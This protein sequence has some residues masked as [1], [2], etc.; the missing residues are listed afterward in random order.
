[1][2]KKFIRHITILVFFITFFSCEK[3]IDKLPGNKIINALPGYMA[4]VSEAEKVAEDAAISAIKAG[5]EQYA[6]EK[7]MGN[8]FRSWPNN[9]WDALV[10]KPLGY[11][12]NDTDNAD[13]YG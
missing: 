11:D 1:M 9:P 2:N 4:S 13:A 5:L 7:L 3:I 8:G 6:L 12:P 10:T